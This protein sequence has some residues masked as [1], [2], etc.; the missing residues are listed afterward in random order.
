MLTYFLSDGLYTELLLYSVLV[1][2]LVHTLAES[3]SV[4]EDIRGRGH[5][6]TEVDTLIVTSLSQ[7]GG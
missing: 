5:G 7:D 4:L 3:V 1:S 2:M 6:D